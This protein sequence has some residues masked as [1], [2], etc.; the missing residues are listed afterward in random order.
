[1]EENK[2]ILLPSKR[3]KK[4]DD[5]EID[6]K[7]GLETSESLM[8]IGDRDIV[9]DIDKLYDKERNESSKYK[10]F[11]KIK[12]VFRNM[13]SGNTEYTYMK[14]RLYL[15]GDG[16]DNN[17]TGFIPYDEFAFLR[18][19]VIREYNQPQSGT[20]LTGYTQSTYKLIGPTGHTLITPITAPYQNWN[21]YL[22]YVY[23]KDLSYS[24]KYSLSGGTSGDTINF[25]SGDGLPFRLSYSGDSFYE[26]TSPVEHG[27]NAGEYITLSGKTLTGAVTGRTFYINSVGNEFYNSKKYVVNILKNQVPSGTTISKIMIGKR[28]LDRNDITRTTS[29]YYV[30]KH[31]TI[32][33][34]DGYILDKVGFETPIWEDER[35]LVFENFSGD[36]DVLVERNRMESVLFDFK[37]PMILSGLTNNLGFTPTEVYV[38]TIFRNGNGYFN[39]PPKVGYK[40]NFHNTW[41]DEHFSGAT[42]NETSLS[43]TTFTGRTW[44]QGYTGFTFT[45]G[46]TISTGTTLIG[47]FVEYNAIELKER[48]ISESFHKLTIP[49]NNFDHNQDD[50]IYYSGSSVNNP[51]GLYYQAHHRVKLRQLSPYIESASTN[52]IYNL[53]ENVVYDATEKLWRWRDL[54]DHGYVDVDGYGT[55]FPFTNGTHYVKTDINLYLRNEQQYNNKQDGLNGFN[56]DC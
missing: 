29:L 37:E 38:T 55:K 30:H 47:A 21:V 35:K 13:Y 20:T 52:D 56:F 19:D 48:T 9:L 5:Q 50:P 18:Q 34:K 17:H 15:V 6:V 53:P 41:I 44:L 14:D 49:T 25:V 46:Q 39:Y 42:K 11:G 51:T 43:G 2:Q 22:S 36:N 26:L 54:Y 27:M 12:M 16:T 23:G 1:M 8:R 40:F 28:V 7:I 24:M 31:K 33:D 4:A 3:Y 45:S 10:I 32:T